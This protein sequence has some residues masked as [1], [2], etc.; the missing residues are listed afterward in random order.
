MEGWWSWSDVT[1]WV[2]V[3]RRRGEWRVSL[4]S[5]MDSMTMGS[6]I[7]HDAIAMVGGASVSSFILD[8][9]PDVIESIID[10]IDGD[11][12]DALESAIVGNCAVLICGGGRSMCAE[13]TCGD[14]MVA[15]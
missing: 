1:R 3:E 9:Y 13:L 10:W 15:G 5:S 11:A 6:G 2:F 4:V 7:E 12:L 14:G 8:E